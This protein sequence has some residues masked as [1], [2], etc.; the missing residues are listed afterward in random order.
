MKIN[1]KHQILLSNKISLMIILLLFILNTNNVLSNNFIFENNHKLSPFSKMLIYRINNTDIQTKINDYQK[2]SAEISKSNQNASFQKNLTLNDLRN[3]I[4]KHFQFMDI[5]NEIYVGVLLLTNGQNI[6]SKIEK[7]GGLVGLV[8]KDVI[9]IKVKPEDLNK[10]IDLVEVLYVQVDEKVGLSLDK[11]RSETKFD[12]LHNGTIT[13]EKIQGDGVI[14]GI[15][16]AGFDFTHSAFLKG[17]TN[18]NRVSRAWIQGSSRRP[19]LNFN[20]GTELI[21]SA[22]SFENYDYNEETHG[23][24]VTGIAAG[25]S[26]FNGNKH[27]GIAP[28]AE[29]VLVSPIFNV[30]QSLTTGQT[31]ILD[32]IK[33]CF[34]YASL[35]KK[36]VVVN[37]SLGTTIGP[38]DG[39]ALFDKAC[40][41]IVGRGKILV[42]AAGNSGESNMHINQNFDVNS[43]PLYTIISPFQTTSNA[44]DCYVELWGEEGKDIEIEVGITQNGSDVWLNKKFKASSFGFNKVTLTNKSGSQTLGTVEISLSASE[45]NRKPRI[46]LSFENVN[47]SYKPIVRITP[48]SKGNIH[49]WNCGLGGSTGGELSNGDN[50]Y[51]LLE[52]G[53]TAKSIISVASYTTKSSTNNIFNKVFRSSFSTNNGDFS[54]FSSKGPSVD[55]RVKPEISAPG[56]LIVSAFNSWSNIYSPN[57]EGADY[58]M[59]NSI[60]SYQNDDFYG[61]FEG[62]SMASPVVAGTVALML[63]V[64][65]DLSTEEAMDII[66]ETAINDKFTGNINATGSTRWGY[67]KINIIES[68]KMSKELGKFFGVFPDMKLYPNPTSNGFDAIFQDTTSGEFEFIIYDNLGSKVSNKSVKFSSENIKSAIYFDMKEYSIGTYFLFISNGFRNKTYLFQKTN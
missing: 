25:N 24:H 16:D 35:A 18:Q 29:I 59:D 17:S 2:K 34:N 66:K 26:Y 19:P 54:P 3:K 13:G 27:S 52:I 42:T 37:M 40:D 38:R 6:Q 9:S 14:V 36:P 50:N 5:N 39:T 45:F 56:S 57:G 44:A 65:P 31:N 8:T 11:V 61:A 28:A 30:N 48:N 46:F 60:L 55:N 4:D 23:T 12:L 43:T 10:I 63:E 7:L 64:F 58:I 32:G 51:T 1:K 53:G 62:T 22:L 15:I 41:N 49:L 67:G 20:Y 47:L 68:V 21:G 33:Y